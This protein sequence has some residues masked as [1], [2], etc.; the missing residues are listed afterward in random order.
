MDEPYVTG[1]EGNAA[2]WVGAGGAV[3]EVSFYY[4]PYCRELGPYLVMATGEEFNFQ[5]EVSFCGG[6]EFIAET[7]LFCPLF[8]G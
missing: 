5:Q 2:V 3:F 1:V 6:K 7:G 4:A 8:R